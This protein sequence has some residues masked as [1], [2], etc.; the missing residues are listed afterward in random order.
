MTNGEGMP[1]HECPKRVVSSQLSAVSQ[2]P[3]PTRLTDT[4]TLTHQGANA[5]A[6]RKIIGFWISLDIRDSAFGIHEQRAVPAR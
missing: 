6:R 1:K 3:I 2:S 4:H 5:P